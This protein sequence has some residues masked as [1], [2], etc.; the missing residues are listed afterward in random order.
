MK[1]NFYFNFYRQLHD[2]LRVDAVILRQ[3]PT[4]SLWSKGD[5]VTVLADSSWKTNWKGKQIRTTECENV[6][7]KHNRK[8]DIG[9][10]RKNEKLYVI[11]VG[12]GTLWVP[13]SK[14]LNSKLFQE[15][16]HGGG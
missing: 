2:L 15:E 8:G 12:G 4:R 1:L 5:I 9:G 11:S 7:A 3:C 13:S 6:R 10:R 14:K 16:R